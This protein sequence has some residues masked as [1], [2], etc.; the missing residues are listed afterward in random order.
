MCCLFG[1][2]DYGRMFSANEKNRILKVL[3]TE[4]EA[5][6][7]DAIIIQKINNMGFPYIIFISYKENLKTKKKTFNWFWVIK[8]LH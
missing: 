6:G 2:I 3:A 7:T 8:L 4:C 5:R 1:L